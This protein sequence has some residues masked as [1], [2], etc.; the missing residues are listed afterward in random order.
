MQGAPEIVRTDYYLSI[1][2]PCFGQ[3]HPQKLDYYS[4]L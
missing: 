3:Q 1:V 4:D 2:E